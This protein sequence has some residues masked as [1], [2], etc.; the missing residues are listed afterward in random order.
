MAI[1]NFEPTIVGIVVYAL[2]L[3]QLNEVLQAI[4]LLFTI[5]YTGYRI[6]EMIDTRK[7]N[8]KKK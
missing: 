3:H 2:S 5:I 1:N 6:I 7:N 4:L 8:N